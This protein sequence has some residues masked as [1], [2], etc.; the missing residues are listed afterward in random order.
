MSSKATIHHHP[1]HP[2]TVVFPLGLWFSSC[3]FDV[4][5]TFSS[6]FVMMRECAFIM[7]LA[8]FSLSAFLRS[9]VPEHRT[10]GA[11]FFSGVGAVVISM[12]AW[13]GHSLVYRYGVGLEPAKEAQKKS[14][15]PA[16]RSQKA[17]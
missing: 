14:P 4:I 11:L 7:L 3:V 1:I 6:K 2:I 5:Y 8:G 12:S 13:L 17:E 10:N 16:R 9:R 15:V